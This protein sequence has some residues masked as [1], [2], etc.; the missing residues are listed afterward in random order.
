MAIHAMRRYH[1][2]AGQVLSGQILKDLSRQEVVPFGFR[3]DDRDA[4][5]EAS[6]EKRGILFPLLLKPGKKG[7]EAAVI[8]GHKRFAW[9]LRKKLKAIPVQFVREK[10]SDK[11][12]FLLSLYSNWNQNFPELD[13]MR[14]LEKAEKDFHFK[15]AEIQEQILPA[16]G[17]VSAGALES[18]RRIAGLTGGIHRLIHGKKLPFQAAASLSRFAEAEQKFL[19][20]SVFNSLHLTSN[21]LLLIADWLTALKK[22]KKTTLEALAGEK[23]IRDVLEHPKMDER[24]RGER[25][26][27]AVYALRFPAL[28]KAG[29][30][31]A[32]LK[33]QL[34]KIEGVR[35]ERP[36]GFESEGLSLRARLKD[37][38][39]VDRIL[40]FLQ[41]QSGPFEKFFN[42][43]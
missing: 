9:A 37:R 11:E 17:L 21:Q 3:F 10:F 12:F 29:K 22:I 2:L 42:P 7:G 41:T 34:E 33:G 15:A 18:H 39:S 6:L 31:F 36:E 40:R 16:L 38:E 5:L 43:E 20:G 8:S 13:R 32:H 4:A 14:A 28:E 35:L 30:K 27:A 26:F 25:F 24:T 19:A 23:S 1:F